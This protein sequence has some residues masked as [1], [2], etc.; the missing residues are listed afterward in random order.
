M[1]FA[2]GAR[3]ADTRALTGR[4]RRQSGRGMNERRADDRIL[5]HGVIK[6]CFNCH[7]GRVRCDASRRS[8]EIW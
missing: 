1:I 5:R 8:L 3:T 6:K 7:A 2:A 4:I